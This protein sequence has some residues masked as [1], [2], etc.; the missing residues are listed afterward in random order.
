MSHFL[1]STLVKKIPNRNIRKK[2]ETKLD[3]NFDTNTTLKKKLNKSNDISNKNRK[4]RNSNSYME[5]FLFKRKSAGEFAQSKRSLSNNKFDINIDELI[6][7]EK[8]INNQNENNAEL[9]ENKDDINSPTFN[10][11]NNFEISQ[12][13]QF[14]KEKEKNNVNN[15][16]DNK[17]INLNKYINK[18][19]NII[20]NKNNC[21][22]YFSNFLTDFSDIN[23]IKNI[24]KQ[25]NDKRKNFLFNDEFNNKKINDCNLIKNK[26]VLND[27]INS[28]FNS[29]ENNYFEP[30]DPDELLKPQLPDDIKNDLINYKKYFSD[31]NNSNSNNNLLSI[32][33]NKINKIINYS[34]NNTESKKFNT[35]EISTIKFN[36]QSVSNETESQI[37]FQE[38]LNN[39]RNDKINFYKTNYSYRNNPH[40]NKYEIT[41]N[42]ADNANDLPLSAKNNNYNK[43]FNNVIPNNKNKNYSLVNF[44]FILNNNNINENNQKNN[45]NSISIKNNVKNDKNNN[46]KDIDEKMPNENKKITIK[47]K[48]INKKEKKDLIIKSK[49][50]E[51]I[52]GEN[53]IKNNYDIN[54][55]IYK[56]GN[57]KNNNINQIKNENFEIIKKTKE[58]ISPKIIISAQ[59]TL[60]KNKK[61]RIKQNNYVICHN[62]N[63]EELKI[64][65][66][67]DLN[68]NKLQFSKEYELIIKKSVKNNDNKNDFQIYKNNITFLNKNLKKE[69]N[70]FNFKI[71]KN[72]ITFSESNLKKENNKIILD[73]SNIDNFKLKSDLNSNNCKQ[74]FLEENINI[75]KNNINNQREK[76]YFE[77]NE[78][79][80][81]ISKQNLIK[82]NINEIKK[83]EK[84]QNLN[85]INKLDNT[86]IDIEKNMIINRHINNNKIF[87]KIKNLENC[88]NNDL[89]KNNNILS[90]NSKEQSKTE[91]KNEKSNKI[92]EK[93]N[94]LKEEI[95]NLIN[96]DFN[97]TVNVLDNNYINT[98]K[99]I[100]KYE[101]EVNSN[102][103]NKNKSN[104]SI[105]NN[106][107]NNK[108]S[109][110]QNIYN[111]SMNTTKNIDLNIKNESIFSFKS[112]QA[113]KNNHN[114]TNLFNKTLT[115]AELNSYNKNFEGNFG[116]SKTIMENYYDNTNKIPD[117][118]LIVEKKN[119]MIFDEKEYKNIRFK[120]YGTIKSKNIKNINLVNTND[121]LWNINSNNE[122]HYYLNRVKE[123]ILNNNPLNFN[124][125]TSN[126]Y[127]K[128]SV[129][130]ISNGN[131]YSLRYNRSSSGFFNKSDNIMP[132][133]N[134]ITKN[135]KLF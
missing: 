60:N 104:Y 80:E 63:F 114:Q 43:D 6:L 37:L 86:K 89:N 61:D 42:I 70:K 39:N 111:S 69:N 126:N 116:K 54:G 117:I 122:K 124:N 33:Q 123:D 83:N 95:N 82:N 17:K 15:M 62:D 130:N 73:I 9:I 77:D 81:N 36:Q 96:K 85:I 41:K 67:Y 27:N 58:I 14:F 134:M 64:N 44:N 23:K 59:F 125:Y 121:N 135:N 91:N 72:N 49:E 97:Q 120:N 20:V 4:I 2:E 53:N 40:K 79:N 22:N 46:L 74:R 18:N 100:S 25:I 38:K 29:L 52:I 93:K 1:S 71:S 78:L 30:T 35:D 101:T 66:N 7:N 76:Y 31:N 129:N 106:D 48:E 133:N 12:K 128:Y 45:L 10:S 103:K 24:K 26:K 109:F 56:E 47:I 102:N 88:F 118:N 105:N 34:S 8:K 5:S 132:V 11:N 13:N 127:N 87:K 98:F 50:Q 110:I 115:L 28:Y 90:E 119:D 113:N 112:D 65:K 92:L 107:K 19:N 75:N 131:I 57:K 16:K 99:K 94:K 108:S 3:S 51:I 55:K 68:K 84:E 21:Y 32:N